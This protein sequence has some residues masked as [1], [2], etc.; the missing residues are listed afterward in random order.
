MDDLSKTDQSMAIIA[1]TFPRF[2]WRMYSNCKAEGF[3]DEQAFDLVA[4]YIKY[5][6]GG[7]T[8]RE[9]GT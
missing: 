9:S 5:V 3:T 2:W 7:Q 4:L 8:K 6:L 1:D